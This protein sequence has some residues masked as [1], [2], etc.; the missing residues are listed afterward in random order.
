MLMIFFHLLLWLPAV[1]GWG[2][3]AVRLLNRIQIQVLDED[4]LIVHWLGLISLTAL[5]T[6][7]NFFVPINW[8]IA[9][10]AMLGGW[11]LWVL[12]GGPK[13]ILND[14]SLS[15]VGFIWLGVVAF[16]ANHPPA[17]YDSGLY[18][19]QS[20][21]WTSQYALSPGLANLHAR[22]GYNSSWF[23]LGA[24][25]QTPTLVQKSAF[26]LSP[27]LLWGMG[28]AV[29]QRAT[30]LLRKE[31]LMISDVFLLICCVGAFAANY[32]DNISSPSP[33]WP[34][35]VIV[36]VMT[37]IFIRVVED[38]GQSRRSTTLLLL[39]SAFAL[40]VKLSALPLVVFPL[41]AAV[42]EGH[43]K[44]GGRIRELS[45]GLTAAGF[46]L[47]PW[48]V[49]GF[50]LSGCL[51]YPVAQSCVPNISWGVPIELVRREALTISAWARMPTVPPE[52]VLSN[53]NWFKL[54]STGMVSSPLV[55]VPLALGF[56]GF[57]MFFIYNRERAQNFNL[58]FV[59]IAPFIAIIYW[60][61]TAPNIR[62]GEGYLWAVGL[63]ILSFGMYALFVYP[64]S[65][66]LNRWGRLI[67]VGSLSLVTVSGFRASV[68][69]TLTTTPILSASFWSEWPSIPESITLPQMV[70]GH[71]VYIPQTTDQCWLA[72]LPCT[73]YLADGLEIRNIDDSRLYFYIV[74][75]SS[76]PSTP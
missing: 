56:V 9:M 47:L 73:P 64:E 20:I 38:R 19:L 2:R 1:S 54:W 49:K 32:W 74:T 44:Q 67:I 31:R 48:M 42:R 14:K 58:V 37:H 10:G 34:I 28:L 40:T 3:G 53:W 23:S 5:A 75:D 11:V 26:I 36:L 45:T 55:I 69:P 21:E 17:S 29:L 4:W 50:L 52:V 30:M 68:L 18:H 59:L 35:F 6:L 8:W 46:L 70:S 66:V 16:A 39:L 13:A 71:T 25:L 7:L 72:P 60:F 22:F 61:V 76:L 12:K 15:L 57:V 43:P 62:F 51:A 63:I 33:D 27:L 41:L 24:I 65:S